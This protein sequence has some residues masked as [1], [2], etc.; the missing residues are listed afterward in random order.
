MYNLDLL[1]FSFLSAEI[2]FLHNFLVI[3]LTLERMVFFLNSSDVCPE[4][5]L[6]GFQPK[7]LFFRIPGRPW[8][9]FQCQRGM[10]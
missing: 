1:F 10:F 9:V 2:I 4:I 5:H 6:R 3:F 7:P 8:Y